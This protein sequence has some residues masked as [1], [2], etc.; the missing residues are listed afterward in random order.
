M[1]AVYCC[2]GSGLTPVCLCRLCTVTSPAATTTHDTIPLVVLLQ[3]QLN[4]VTADCHCPLPLDTW[5]PPLVIGCSA[6]L[7]SKVNHW[8]NNIIQTQKHNN[9][10]CFSAFLEN[11]LFDKSARESVHLLYTFPLC[12]VDNL[13]ILRDILV[14]KSWEVS[15]STWLQIIVSCNA[16]IFLVR[17]FSWPDLKSN[18]LIFLLRLAFLI[19]FA[20]ISVYVLLWVTFM[21]IFP[22]FY[23]AIHFTHY[24]KKKRRKKNWLKLF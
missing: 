12:F 18:L 24:C 13:I 11:V 6:H 17:H 3:C 4:L 15:F 9:K 14:F 23:F 1:S 21:L 16:Q 5:S 19:I 20:W 10:Q 7:V 22:N 2:S 8:F